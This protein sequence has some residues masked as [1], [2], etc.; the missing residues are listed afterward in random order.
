MGIALENGDRSS[1]Y[2]CIDKLV[3]YEMSS[4]AG[5]E[6]LTDR[7]MGFEKCIAWIKSQTYS[8]ITKPPHPLLNEIRPA[9]A[10]LLV[11]LSSAAQW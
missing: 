2:N 10:Y 9:Q 5:F 4:S 11:C 3:S 7:I 6:G 8:H 1:S